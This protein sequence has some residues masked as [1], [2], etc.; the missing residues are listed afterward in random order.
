MTM[1]NNENSP[2]SLVEFAGAVAGGGGVSGAGAEHVGAPVD[3]QTLNNHNFLMALGGVARGNHPGA[4][5]FAMP[6]SVNGL[7]GFNGGALIFVSLSNFLAALFAF[8]TC[9]SQFSGRVKCDER[10]SE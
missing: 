9:L 4:P 7:G 5:H 1:T 6:V 3:M 10:D 8:S 2:D